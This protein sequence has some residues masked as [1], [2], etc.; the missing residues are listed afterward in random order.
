MKPCSAAPRLPRTIV[1]S[2]FTLPEK[3]SATPSSFS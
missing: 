2:R 3:V 1:A